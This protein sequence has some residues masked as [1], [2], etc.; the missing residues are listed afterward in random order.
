MAAQK[1][2]PE[3]Q[4][5]RD[6]RR[7][8][9]R[10]YGKNRRKLPW[11]GQTDPYRILVSEVMLQQTRVAVVEERYKQFLSRFPTMRKLARADEQSVLAAW[12][13][14]GYYRRARSLRAA[15]KL[16][17]RQRGFPRTPAELEAL[18]GVGRYTANAVASIAFGE[19]VPVVDGNVQRVLRR[20]LGGALS[21]EQCWGAAGAL[22]D[23]RRP[24]D[25]NQAMM[26]LGAV[27][28]LPE[29]PLCQTCPVAASCVSRGAKSKVR[30]SSRQKAV[31][32]YA[33][34]YNNGA[35]LLEQRPGNSSLM[36]AMWELPAISGKPHPGSTLLLTL[37]HSITTT[38]YAVSVFS[39][40]SKMCSRKR[41]VPLRKTRSMAL[42]GLTKKILERICVQRNDIA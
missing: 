40:S 3:F 13:G 10:W 20:V 17:L 16:V 14:L 26:E 23:A 12:S 5:A 28:C 39:E 21:H 29:K 8:L 36:P 25:F 42:T 35:V 41:W 6:F 1:S 2:A 30:R 4:S 27:V 7:Q 24:G 22:L 38:D 15:A 9:L 19:A 32:R 33:L 18:P 34:A 31:L 37:R 11:R